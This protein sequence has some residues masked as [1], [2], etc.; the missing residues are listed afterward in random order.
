[1]LWFKFYFY[2]LPQNLIFPSLCLSGVYIISSNGSRKFTS[3]LKWHQNNIKSF[4]WQGRYEC[5]NMSI[6]LRRDSAFDEGEV[7]K[8]SHDSLFIQAQH[9]KS[10]LFQNISKARELH[11]SFPSLPGQTKIKGPCR[12]RSALLRLSLLS[13]LLFAYCHSRS[14]EMRTLRC[15]TVAAFVF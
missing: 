1:M 10:P 8:R 11:S 14:K 9:S 15:V 4:F 5:R 2:T 7:R 12:Q 13:H 6:P 3:S